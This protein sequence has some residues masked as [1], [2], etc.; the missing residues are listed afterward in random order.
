[1]NITVNPI[2][3]PV[4]TPVAAICS[5]ASLADLPVDSNN[6]INGQW[7][8]AIN[9]VETTLYTFTPT[10]G[11]CAANAAMS[12]V[13]NPNVTPIFTQVA[14]ICYGDTGAVLPVDS[15]NGING[16][17][18]L[19]IDNTTTTTYAFTPAAGQCA[20]ATEMTIA[21][22]QEVPAP[23]G[24]AT[25]TFCDGETVGN[26][27]V[28]GNS[29][30]WYDAPAN[31]NIVANSTVLSAGI[32]YYAAQSIASCQSNN[33][34]AV[35]VSNG[36]CLGIDTQEKARVMVFPNPIKN[37]LNLSYQE[38]ITKVIIYNT[39]GQAVIT[40]GINAKECTIDT[41]NLSPGTYMV[42]IASSKKTQTIKVIKE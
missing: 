11:Q 2:V 5:G 18:S 17:W 24:S 31:G 3:I 26:I 13:V 14:P 6:G 15:A 19:V 30:V 37:T 35:T 7:S 33:R 34:L 27:I 29:V 8:P 40:K 36:T 21:V 25:Q 41:S 9:N 42:K 4:F 12:I 16:T 10:T 32:T 38:E 23:T 39:I 28:E 1:M 22:S 20:T